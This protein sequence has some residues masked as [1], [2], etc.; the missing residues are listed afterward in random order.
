MD[1]HNRLE[2]NDRMRELAGRR[3]RLEQNPEALMTIPLRGGRGKI[4]LHGQDLV[5]AWIST[6]Y[7]NRTFNVI[8]LKCPRAEINQL[9]DGEITILHPMDQDVERFFTACRAQTVRRLSAVHLEKLLT[10]GAGTRFSSG[11]QGAY[12]PSEPRTHLEAAPDTP[13][14]EIVDPGGF[15]NA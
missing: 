3:F 14:E 13:R 5:A 2:V 15:K 8:K 4:Y 10:S 12:G 6:N 7:P 9:G 1:L 11:V